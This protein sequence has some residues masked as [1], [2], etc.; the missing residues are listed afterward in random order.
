MTR[1]KLAQI[2][3]VA[4]GSGSPRGD[5]TIGNVVR[6]VR[7]VDL[8]KDRVRAMYAQLER[9]TVSPEELRPTRSQFSLIDSTFTEAA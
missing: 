9:S 3:G 8:S 2:S 7:A 1:P 5:L 4:A 6:L